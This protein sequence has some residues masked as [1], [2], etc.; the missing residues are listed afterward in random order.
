[1]VTISSI[2]L[3]ERLFQIVLQR[4]IALDQRRGVLVGQQGDLEQ[5]RIGVGGTSRVRATPSASAGTES[6][7]P[8]I[9]FIATSPL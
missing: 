7:F 5:R 4:L 3:L 8:R 6:G 9:R 1:M 2:F